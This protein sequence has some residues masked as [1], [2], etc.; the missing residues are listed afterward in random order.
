MKPRESMD[1]LSTAGHLAKETGLSLVDFSPFGDPS[2]GPSFALFSCSSR[3]CSNQLMD[4][5]RGSSEGSGTVRGWRHAWR[6][7]ELAAPLHPILVHFTIALFIAS[8]AGDALGTLLGSAS[9]REGAWWMMA[10]SFLAT[11]P[12]LVTGALSRRRLPIQEGEARS[13]LRAHMAIGFVVFGLLT[14]LTLWRAWLWQLGEPTSL[15]YLGV[16]ALLVLVMTLQGYLGGELVYRYGAEVKRT[17]RELPG[18]PAQSS[19]PALFP[20]QARGKR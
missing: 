12:T 14:V 10:G 1:E 16:A 6:A 19:P 2:S 20:A 9:L 13:F 17:Y 11:P 3:T 7:A 5:A 18:R 15:A 4:I 8:A